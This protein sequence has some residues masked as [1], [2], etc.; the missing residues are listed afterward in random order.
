MFF[1][2]FS[3]TFFYENINQEHNLLLDCAIET[4]TYSMYAVKFVCQAFLSSFLTC[5]VSLAIFYL[6]QWQCQMEIICSAQNHIVTGRRDNWL[7]HVEWWQLVRCKCNILCPTSEVKS[8]YGKSQ[9]VKGSKLF[10]SY[11]KMFKLST[12]QGLHDSTISDLNCSWGHSAPNCERSLRLG[13]DPSQNLT[14]IC[15]L[16]AIYSNI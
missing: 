10:S 16:V 14:K 11:R 4:F 2:L 13:H 12:A 6:D 9:S 3:L 8:V 15:Q 1:S 5:W 7:V